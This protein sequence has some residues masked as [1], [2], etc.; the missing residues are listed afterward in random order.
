MSKNQ[1]L[2][3]VYSAICLCLALVLPFFTGQI[4]ILGKMLNLM[5]FAIFLCGLLCGGFY[6]GVIGFIA[7]L[8]RSVT[9]GMPN[10]YPNAVGM[11]FELCAYGL[12]SGLIYKVL[13]NVKGSVIISLIGAMLIGRIVWGITT[14]VLWSFMGDVFTFA[15]FIKGAFIDSVVG[16]AL[17]LL[18]IP[19][20]VRI[21]EK[22][23]VAPLAKD[24][25]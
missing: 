3:I 12:V 11:A 25:K 5:H 13:H 6:G 16:I 22:A 2:K 19:L 14:L 24:S 20:I 8:L 10:L 15:L 7:P 1:T 21:L 4:R 17:Q 18:V 23:G 9:F